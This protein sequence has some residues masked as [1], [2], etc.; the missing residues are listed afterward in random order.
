TA[1]ASRP[2]WLPA[3]ILAGILLLAGGAMAYYASTQRSAPEGPRGGNRT[4]EVDARTRTPAA[5]R[6][7]PAAKA[8]AKDIEDA[9]AAERQRLEAQKRKDAA[10]APKGPPARAP[11]SLAAR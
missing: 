4:Y 1:S 7:D 3:A 8:L 6:D 5:V 10:P 9:A 2:R 11:G